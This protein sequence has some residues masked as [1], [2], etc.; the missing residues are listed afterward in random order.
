[1]V[2]FASQNTQPGK[3]KTVADILAAAADLIEPEG[4]WTQGTSYRDADGD[5]RDGGGPEVVC[6]CVAGAVNEVCD[7][8]FDGAVPA[9]RLLE[10]HVGVS[11]IARW[12]DAP[13]RTQ[14]EVVAALR[15]ASE[16]AR[17]AAETG[18]VGT[19]AEPE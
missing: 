8:S 4:A 6:R 16:K 2:H 14:A 7:W 18:A 12:N 13:E 5:I 17:T 11:D 1:M 15:A 3:S 9:F 19:T 10:A